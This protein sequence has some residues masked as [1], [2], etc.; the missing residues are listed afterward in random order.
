MNT[1]LKCLTRTR[2]LVTLTD[3]SFKDVVLL[4]A[5]ERVIIL[6]GPLRSCF[7]NIVYYVIMC[8][9]GVGFVRSFPQASALFRDIDAHGR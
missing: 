2:Q 5:G 4:A 7:D 6:A 1:S 3:K 9:V 8:S